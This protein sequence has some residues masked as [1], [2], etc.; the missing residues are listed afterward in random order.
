MRKGEKLKL[1]NGADARRVMRVPGF[2]R[3]SRAQ[4]TMDPVSECIC[5]TLTGAQLTVSTAH[6]RN[7]QIDS[8]SALKTYPL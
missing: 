8:F 5:Y 6:T 1:D 3:S 2:E 4:L 7:S